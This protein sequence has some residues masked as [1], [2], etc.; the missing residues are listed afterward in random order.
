MAE[1]DTQRNSTLTPYSSPRD[2]EDSR[3]ID[4]RLMVFLP[5]EKI[6]KV[7]IVDPSLTRREYLI[8]C[9]VHMK[10]EYIIKLVSSLS[11]ACLTM[12]DEEYD[13]VFMDT[14]ISP[15]AII[16]EKLDQ[17]IFIT[18]T[19]QHVLLR[20]NKSVLGITWPYN[21]DRIR[22]LIERYTYL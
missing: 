14:H 11:E 9:L 18:S 3:F 2:P 10:I 22:N 15:D 13:L 5:K 7:L 20:N 16:G 6:A 17:V 8:K 1:V 4:K 12:R 21:N 19:H